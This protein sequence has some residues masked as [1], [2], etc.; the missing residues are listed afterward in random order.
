MSWSSYASFGK[1]KKFLPRRGRRVGATTFCWVSVGNAAV[2][3]VG[4]LTD[5]SSAAI[6]EV[7]F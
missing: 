3:G 4:G 7:L 2:S 5:W 6:A 1:S